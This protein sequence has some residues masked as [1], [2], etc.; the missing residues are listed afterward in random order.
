MA[1]EAYCGRH[2]RRAALQELNKSVR[3]LQSPTASP[4]VGAGPRGSPCKD[5][6]GHHYHSGGARFAHVHL[7]TLNVMLSALCSRTLGTVLK[8]E[9]VSETQPCR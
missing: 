9:V 1:L 8:Y 6:T 5:A 2:A 3:R 4:R 7:G